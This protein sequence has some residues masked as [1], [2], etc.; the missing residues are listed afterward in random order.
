MWQVGIDGSITPF[1]W[2][3]LSLGSWKLRTECGSWDKDL[4]VGAKSYNVSVRSVAKRFP[5]WCWMCLRSWFE[6]SSSCTGT[7][8]DGE[9]KWFLWNDPLVVHLDPAMGWFSFPRL[10]LL[11]AVIPQLLGQWTW[12]CIVSPNLLQNAKAS[13]PLP[14]LITDVSTEHTDQLSSN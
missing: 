11:V 12:V 5:Y 2:L 13:P 4:E 9:Q 7:W 10:L 14:V 1:L 6:S 8:E 3:F